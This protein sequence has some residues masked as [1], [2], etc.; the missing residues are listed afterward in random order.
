MNTTYFI[1]IFKKLN[2]SLQSSEKQ[3]LL[4]RAAHEHDLFYIAWDDLK[5]SNLSVDN[6]KKN[7]NSVGRYLCPGYGQ[8]ILVS[9]NTILAAVN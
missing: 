9:R 2:L 3:Q 5:S 7:T 6:F 4:K 1:C 8:S